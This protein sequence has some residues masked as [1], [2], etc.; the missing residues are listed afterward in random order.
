M[1]RKV[2][3]AYLQA[4]KVLI[5]S[6]SCESKT[7]FARQAYVE[8]VTSHA[9]LCTTSSPCV[10]DIIVNVLISCYPGDLTRLNDKSPTPCEDIH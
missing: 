4:Y 6:R 9:M 1:Q 7:L 3:T 8:L 10:L 2:Q 5:T